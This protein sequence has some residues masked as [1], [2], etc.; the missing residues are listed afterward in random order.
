VI[1]LVA[2]RQPSKPSSQGQ[3]SAKE[4]AALQEK[5]SRGETADLDRRAADYV[6]LIGGQVHIN[7][8]ERAITGAAELPEE[9]FRLTS[10]TLFDNKQVTDAGLAH[11]KD[12]KNLADLRLDGTRVTD[13]G[14]A[15]FKDCENLTELYLRDTQVSDGS[16]KHLEGLP[17]LRKLD[18]TGTQ[19]T[20]EGI[21][22]LKKVLPEC[23]VTSG[24]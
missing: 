20:T 12:C 19:V 23:K 13:T 11:F 2:R 14:L 15:Y 17:N 21:D 18:L 24:G 3:P 22:A 1:G 7:D 8:Q 16:L 5:N 6:L 4:R 9:P 10:V